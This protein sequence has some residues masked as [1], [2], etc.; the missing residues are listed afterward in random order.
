MYNFF[1]TKHFVLPG[2]LSP[3]AGQVFDANDTKMAT[4]LLDNVFATLP[5]LTA[6]ASGC[7]NDVE[8]YDV[9][10]VSNIALGAMP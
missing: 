6:L 4:V 10:A 9:I 5:T 3:N 2:I 7:I 1:S 8:V